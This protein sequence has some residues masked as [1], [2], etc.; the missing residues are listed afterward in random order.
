M[1]EP[2]LTALLGLAATIGLVHTLM[3]VDHY[4]PFL[5]I[6]RARGWS[7]RRVLGITALCGVGHVLS[8]VVLGSVGIGLGV[9]IGRL[10]WFEAT[11][12]SVAAWALIGFGLAYFAWATWRVLRGRRHEHA[13]VHADGTVHKHPHDHAGEHA[14]PHGSGTVTAWTLFVIFVLGPCEPLI[15]L[16]MA[17][18]AT[19]D[20]AAV[21]LVTGT[22]GAVTLASMLAATAIGYHGLRLPVFARVE[23]WANSL[24]GLAIA[25][26]GLAIQTLGL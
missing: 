1:T 20:W 15:P 26:S 21:V 4:L 13:H 7:L 18:A 3:G 6:G 24:A 14:H 23:R 10:E 5:V 25:G 11:R 12:G 22:F 16:L 2:T 9:A 17:P 8:S 19:L